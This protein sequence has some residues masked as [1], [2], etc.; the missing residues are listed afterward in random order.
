MDGF[1]LLTLVLLTI[2]MA[3]GA[4]IGGMVPVKLSMSYNKVNNLSFFGMGILIGTSLVLIIPEG[5]QVMYKSLGTEDIE[6]APMYIGL[7][8]IL[9]F[10]LMFIQDNI[11]MLISTFNRNLEF[12]Y[13]VLENANVEPSIKQGFLSVFQ[14]SLTLG[15]IL[16]AFI[17]GISM[18]SSFALEDSSMGI[19]FFIII[20]IHKIPTAFSLTSILIKEGLNLKLIQTHLIVF[21]LM[22]PLGAILTYLMI[23]IFNSTKQFPIAILFLFSAG[24]FLYVIHHV[25]A[26]V[27]SREELEGNN[28][29]ISE[30]AISLGGAC[31]PV[32]L[33]LL[34]GE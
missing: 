23:A 4:Y 33:S 22:T 12:N 10:L 3:I 27:A 24:T 31:I 29:N 7:S 13:L 34:G 19:I 32:I 20:I 17:D 2:A 1:R 28:L 30:F 16:H 9:G 18:G 25:M 11:P 8:L 5:V 14:S 26:Q 21:A 15:L 6:K